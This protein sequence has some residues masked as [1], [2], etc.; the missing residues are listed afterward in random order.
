MKP[1]EIMTNAKYMMKMKKRP[2]DC[3]DPN[4]LPVDADQSI[5]QSRPPRYD[6]NSRTDSSQQNVQLLTFSKEEYENDLEA[7]S[8]EDEKIRSNMWYEPAS[9]KYH[10]ITSSQPRPEEISAGNQTAGRKIVSPYLDNHLS[11]YS[12]VDKT[13]WSESKENYSG[14]WLCIFLDFVIS[15]SG[16]FSFEKFD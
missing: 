10:Y 6:V 4:S 1:D 12:P 7:L 14:S 9:G 16:G 13:S 15:F 3:V 5:A 8:R 11:C 2:L